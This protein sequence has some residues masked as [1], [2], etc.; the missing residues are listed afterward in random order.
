MVTSKRIRRTYSFGD[1]FREHS[2]SSESELIRYYLLKKF[3]STGL[4]GKQGLFQVI[5]KNSL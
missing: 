1:Q 4:D 5:T 2:K 3:R